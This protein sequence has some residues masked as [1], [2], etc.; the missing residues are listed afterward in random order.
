MKHQ[1]SG[2][3]DSFDDPLTGAEEAAE[4]S[5]DDLWFLPGSIEDEPDDLPPGPRAEPRET[6]IVDDWR[7]RDGATGSPCSKRPT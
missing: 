1:A 2:P 5:E 7:L 6:A 4:R 3:L